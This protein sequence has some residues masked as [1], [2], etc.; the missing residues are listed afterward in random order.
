MK[1]KTDKDKHKI[2]QSQQ[3]QENNVGKLYMGILNS[4][5]KEIDLV[6]LFRLNTTKYL[7][8]TCSLNMR[9]KNKTGQSKGYTFV[10][11]PKRVC[12]ELLNLN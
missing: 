11:A 6:E 2:N 1:S 10:S 9:M 4:S 5:I 8:E 7:I 12:N 3:K